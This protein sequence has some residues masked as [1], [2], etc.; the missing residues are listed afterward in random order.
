M[1]T[2]ISRTVADGKT[3]LEPIRGP[4]VGSRC[5]LRGEVS[6]M[7]SVLSGFSWS[8][9][10]DIQSA[11]AVRHPVIFC[12]RAPTSASCYWA[13]CNTVTTSPSPCHKVSHS[14]WPLPLWALRDFWMAPYFVTFTKTICMDHKTAFIKSILWPLQKP[15]FTRASDAAAC[16]MRA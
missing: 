5:W 6:H 12:S 14:E 15:V 16:T 2:P 9:L 13:W 1:K 10:A 4:E 7:N 11:T 8:R 3:T